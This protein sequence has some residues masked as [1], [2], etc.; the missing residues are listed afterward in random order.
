MGLGTIP[1]SLS[2]ALLPTF[3]G[4]HSPTKID[5]RKKG[6][7]ALNSLLEDPDP[8]PEMDIIRFEEAT[9]SGT[10]K[11]QTQ[12]VRLRVWLQGC[13][14]WSKAVFFWFQH[15]LF[16]LVICRITW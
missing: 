3:S 2:S 4:E 14:L 11:V 7:L 15:L 6:T 8:F 5:G 10:H 16:V 9:K 12:E 1:R 13:T